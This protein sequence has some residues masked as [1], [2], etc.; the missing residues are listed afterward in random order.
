[1]A[2]V[3]SNHAPGFF[4]V[5]SPEFTLSGIFQRRL[6]RHLNKIIQLNLRTIFKVL[7]SLGDSGLTIRMSQNITYIQT[8]MGT[9]VYYFSSFL[10]TDF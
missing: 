1:M 10:L 7:T 8:Y 4:S 9:I 6:P 5:E 3:Y 2:S